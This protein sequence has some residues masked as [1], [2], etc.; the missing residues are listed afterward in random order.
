M[1]PRGSEE[2]DNVTRHIFL[3]E[4]QWVSAF[5]ESGEAPQKTAA[6]FTWTAPRDSVVRD[7]AWAGNNW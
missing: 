5:V 6:T 4:P 7:L 1:H 3:Q 2:G